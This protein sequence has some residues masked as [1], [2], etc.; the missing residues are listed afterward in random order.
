MMINTMVTSFKLK[1]TYKANSVIFSLKAMPLIKSLLPQSL[2]SNPALKRF[3]N[4]LGIISK[5]LMLFLG[6]AA[7]IA[8]IFAAA[9]KLFA[10]VN[11]N[12]INI[13]VF[14]TLIGGILNTHMFTPTRDK[15]Y[16][17]VLMRMDA[18]EYTLADYFVYLLETFIGF[19]PFTIIFGMLVKL[20]IAACLL[21][22]VFIVFVKICFTALSIRKC[23]N[24]KNVEKVNSISKPQGLCI[25][26][27]LAAAFVAPYFGYAVNEVTLYILTAVMI[28]PTAFSLKY[29]REF[30]DFRT[31]Y[32]ILLK[33]E[34][35]I[36]GGTKN[37]A[38]LSQQSAFQKKI[39]NGSVTVSHK[40]GYKYFNEIFMKRHS[41]ILTRSAIKIAKICA[42][43]VLGLV[44]CCLIWPNIKVLINS[45]MLTG[46]PY[47]LI[48]MYLIN[49]G[50]VITQ[51]MFMNCDH[52]M[53]AYRFYRQPKAI[54]S[55]FV[56]RLKY[57]VLVNMIPAAVIAI[58][59]PL[60]LFVSGGTDRA[61]NYLV[62][63]L[64]IMAMS[65]FFSVHNMVLY[66]L[67]QPYNISLE[68]KSSLYSL[69][70]MGTYFLCV[71]AMGKAAP[72]LAF[73]IIISVF[74]IVYAVIAIILA[75]LFA[76]KTFKLR[77]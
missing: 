70:N 14:F 12:F 76:P 27:F 61:L 5:F 59:T 34:N 25:L 72:T 16:A 1:N 20:N 50:K 52:S 57:V 44:V 58:G 51:A 39:S 13:L 38:A 24:I 15:F 29:I 23:K 7:Y 28:V 74:C 69:V 37:T 66:Y 56:E 54:V 6:K 8:L 77:K 75:Y 47:F 4:V 22:P 73:G 60:L 31:V 26:L 62:L 46:M 10:P 2:Y 19:L 55:L 33:P 17:V 67:F 42:A 40:T 68:T 36:S 9:S 64:T 65:V 48:I 3:A 53:L 21:L 30:N 45:G 43:I 41:V 11:N 32:K 63:F 49:R 18:R 35:Y 71:F